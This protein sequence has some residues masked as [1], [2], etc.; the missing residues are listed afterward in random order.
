MG[1]IEKA[2][3]QSGATNYNSVISKA[4]GSSGVGSSDTYERIRERM[5]EDR[6]KRQ[7]EEQQQAVQRSQEQTQSA[8]QEFEATQSGVKGWLNKFLGKGVA[9]PTLAGE[10]PEYTQERLASEQDVQRGPISRIAGGVKSF[11]KMM[12]EGERNLGEGLGNILVMG[13]VAEA[14]SKEVQANAKIIIDLQKRLKNQTGDQKTTELLDRLRARNEELTSNMKTDLTPQELRT[15]VA[16]AAETG[17]DVGTL[18]LSSLA[19]GAFKTGAKMLGKNL[20]K[21]GG[22]QIAKK[23]ALQTAKRVAKSPWTEAGLF[24]GVYGAT[25]VA[26]EEDPTAGDYVKGGAVG[27]ALGLG[28][29]L[30]GVGLSKGASKLLEKKIANK[31]SIVIEK[32]VGSLAPEEK[33]LL[34]EAIKE[35]KTKDEIVAE[36]KKVREIEDIFDAEGVAGVEKLAEAQRT[37]ITLKRG[38][39]APAVKEVEAKTGKLKV[40]EI[41]TVK[42]KLEQGYSVDEIADDFIN[43]TPVAPVRTPVKTKKTATAT[44]VIVPVKKQVPD[45]SSSLNKRDYENIL[46]KKINEAPAP[47]KGEVTVIQTGDGRYVDTQIDE[48][49]GSGITKDTKVFNV[50]KENLDITSDAEKNLRGERLL[51]AEEKIPKESGLIE[52]AKAQKT[53]KAKLTAYKKDKESFIND[54]LN[55]GEGARIFGEIE[56]RIVAKETLGEINTDILSGIKNSS[57][58]KKEGNIKDSMGSGYLMTSQKGRK[59][60]VSADEA[61]AY[62]GRGWKRGPEV[63]SLA[64]EAGF[65][66]GE[67]Y[68]NYTLE[69]A[70]ELGSLSSPEKIAHNE[71]LETD[72]AYKALDSEITKLKKQ[73]NEKEVSGIVDKKEAVIEKSSI[74]AKK[75]N[76]RFTNNKKLSEKYDVVEINK[77]SEEAAKLISENENKA[78]EKA[79][80]EGGNSTD[81]VAILS[82]MWH[83]SIKDGGSNMDS[84]LFNKIKTLST[85]TAQ[86]MNMFKALTETNPHFSYMSE[87]V[88]SK[89]KN[90]IL[91]SS[92]IKKAVGGLKPSEAIKKITKEKKRLVKKEIMETKAKINIKKAQEILNNLIC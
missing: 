60:V 47:K 15:V 23:G 40:A 70:D 56:S 54:Y 28:L 19:K 55:S 22:E 3:Q 20:A 11:G 32:E 87:I 90:L 44:E 45:T 49:L 86:T 92:K 67:D 10:T 8:L 76:A 7:A 72:E 16:G 63:D 9:K 88:D 2:R 4:R 62:E 71:L 65:D 14:Q 6:R 74:T 73:I 42:T 58:Y 37:P 48:A 66:N 79:F 75:M 35:G 51:K 33:T 38:E 24:G 17:I 39:L 85:E 61:Q 83:K 91:K 1:I 53:D 34:Q 59:V 57:F 12:T 89:L 30:A 13:D 81:K 41:N 26:R 21:E 31:A 36:I 68:L 78:F 29:G 27:T 52:T 77:K 64:K 84:A 80:S 43:P 25:S 82:E 18:G 50:K 46:K 69:Q 5:E